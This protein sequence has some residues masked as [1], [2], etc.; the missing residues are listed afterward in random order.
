MRVNPNMVPD[1]L[2]AIAR[3]QEA[4]SV[5]LQQISTGRRVNQPSDDPAAAAAL[6]QNH[7]RSDVVDQ[8]TQNG[9]TVLDMMQA[10]ESA[11][12][13]VV[14]QV[15]QAVTLGVGGANGT[16]SD[17][18]RETL[19]QQV[20]GILDDVV[21]QA[22]FSY[23]GTH[24]FAGTATPTAPF[25]TDPTSPSGYK[26]NGNSNVNSVAIGDGFTI[27]INVAGNQLFQHP[28]G[29]LLGSLQQLAAALRGGDTATI[30]TAT[31]Q[32]RGALD[33]LT[34]Q[35]VFYGNIT[36]QIKLQESFLQ[37][38]TVNIKAQETALV[39]VDMATAAIN[40]SQAQTASQ[41][42]LAVAAKV[43]PET[44]LDYLR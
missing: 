37:N 24:L 26:Y 6:V 30:G 40:F 12:S 42:T 32:L 8:Y 44:L 20:S 23:R 7:T 43:L 1:V 16:L 17:G 15:S 22:N 18:D 38:E 28:G 14:N 5:A 33:Y 3:T 11:L 34:Q 36:S 31:N 19:A 2:S 27:P 4:Q 25:T 9:S 39:G 10:A 21:S 41:A 13:S 35:R 29:D